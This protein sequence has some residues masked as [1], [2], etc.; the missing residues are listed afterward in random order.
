[1]SR[2]QPKASQSTPTTRLAKPDTKSPAPARSG[3]TL[4][5]HK[6]SRNR[7]L[8]FFLLCL[9][10]F[11]ALESFLFVDVLKDYNYLE[12]F[13]RELQFV[14][15]MNLTTAVLI[16]LA[17][18]FIPW[19][20]RL[21]AK[22]VSATLLGLLMVNYDAR[23]AD[24]AGVYRALLP[25]SPDNELPFVSILFLATLLALAVLLGR[26]IERLQAKHAVL[27]GDNIVWAILIVVGFLFAGQGSKLLQI[28]PSMI[29]Q[30]HTVAPAL[31]KPA[32]KADA[33]KPDIYYLVLDRYASDQTLREQFN[34]I[35]P[36]SSF[37]Q[38][39][40][41]TVK[42]NAFANY[43]YTTISISSTL[44]AM[45]TNSI[46][47]PYKNDKVQTR[48]LYHNL[49]RQSSVIKALKE[50]GYQYH[51]VG[52]WYG[53]SN[54]APLADTEHM[55]E[56][57][58]TIFGR[59]KRLRNMEVTEFLKS[60]YYRLGKASDIP[61]WPLKTE[62]RTEVEDVR[63]QLDTL[64][65]LSSSKEQGGRFIFAH[66]LVPHDPF[67]FNGDGSLSENIG[68]DSL[69]KPIKDKYLGQVEFINN[70]IQG[71]VKNINERS[72]GKA[73]VILS[74]DEGPY[75]NDMN[76][77][78][79]D[80]ADG[81]ASREGG[82]IKGDMRQW[83][84]DWL[85]MKLGVQQAVHIPKA[86]EDDLNHL[87]S[88]NLFRIVLNRYLGYDLPYLPDCH[89]ALSVG[90]QSEFNYGDVSGRLQGDVDPAC[91]QQESL[92]AK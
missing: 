23:L 49:I 11:L 50:N 88:T 12:I 51:S 71:I 64:E 75:P 15:L 92:P 89:Y 78:F 87:T 59:E 32:S 31:P 28:L 20:R 18:Y 90:T 74:A 9:P 68:T 38:S 76:A 77:T 37:L 2:K 7:L 44:N 70:Q 22:L 46:V 62:D 40:D 81:N 33:E 39:Q 66:I 52:S 82:I 53:A 56:H 36:L 67:Y 73:V 21:S 25:I 34:Y 45:Y 29:E 5:L 1:M 27:R 14:T 41:F 58:V 60:P 85:K 72:S 54:R 86:T 24:I 19:P 3:I 43:P 83:P 42:D 48:A 84:D 26:W 69:G 47:A 79:R 35:N 16:G 6:L 30:S 10:P 4:T 61:G 17:I 91:K 55:W 8:R 63:A 57:M 80:P 65:G 13:P